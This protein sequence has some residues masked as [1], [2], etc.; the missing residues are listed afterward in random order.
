MKDVRSA[1]LKPFLGWLVAAAAVAF[2]VR[3][4]LANAGRIPHVPLNETTGAVGV[5][6][7]FFAL[8]AIVLSGTIWQVLLHDQAVDRPWQRVMSLYL[9]AQFGK[10]LPGNVG[11]YVGR[12]VLARDMGIPVPVTLATMVTEVLWAVGSALALSVVSIYLF[13]GAGLNALPPWMNMGGL[14]LCVVGLFTSPWLGVTLAKR[15]VPSL[16][17][18][19]FGKHDLA[20]PGW[21]AALKVSLLYVGCSLCLGLILQWQ[22]RYLFGAVQ[23]PLLQVSGFFAFAWLVGYVLPGA[24]AGIGVRESM[25]V[26]LFTPIFGEG[27]AL[28]LGVT[29]RLAT[30]LADVLAFLAGWVWRIAQSRRVQPP[31]GMSK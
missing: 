1:R 30:T 20:P 14:V 28:A 22:S 29:L 26:L 31:Q 16:L 5:A 27:T 15:W 2:F 11:Q 12:V 10:Y 6:S 4:V 9:V 24:P 18:R 13:V 7:I 8:L 19:L 17:V 25:M 3:R 23:A 21:R